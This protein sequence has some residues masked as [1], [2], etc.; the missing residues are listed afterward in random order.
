MKGIINCKHYEQDVLWYFP[1]REQRQQEDIAILQMQELT[2]Q[3]REEDE[4]A[5]IFERDSDL[6]NA[7]EEHFTSKA[8]YKK[9]KANVLEKKRSKEEA[10]R[11]EQTAIIEERREWNNALAMSKRKPKPALKEFIPFNKNL[12]AI[13]RIEE[14]IE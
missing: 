2:K 12:R 11:V 9:F 6:D 10:D 1:M 4:Q 3:L 13:E 8:T 5:V 7:D 14:L